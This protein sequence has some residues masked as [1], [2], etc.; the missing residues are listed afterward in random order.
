MSEDYHKFCY[1]KDTRVFLILIFFV[2]SL[3][4]LI[5]LFTAN[6]REDKISSVY[7]LIV[8]IY[9]LKGLSFCSKKIPVETTSSYIVVNDVKLEWED[10]EWV[11]K[12][13]DFLTFSIKSSSLS[14]YRVI[15]RYGISSIVPK[16]T[17]LNMIFLS[18]KDK[19]LL[20]SIIEQHV[21]VKVF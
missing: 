4:G 2:S 20:L 19:E 14:K 21:S 10:I 12:K 5:L 13:R 6:D 11:E 16:E 1:D 8:A 15:G 18:N 7:S 17:E 9:C 3:F